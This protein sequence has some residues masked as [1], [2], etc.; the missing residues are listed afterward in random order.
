MLI[1][2]MKLFQALC[3]VTKLLS[4]YIIFKYANCVH[5]A[6]VKISLF[7]EFLRTHVDFCGTTRLTVERT[8]FDSLKL[9]CNFLFF[10]SKVYINFFANIFSTK[11]RI[12][13]R[14]VFKGGKQ[15]KSYWNL[16]T[17]KRFSLPILVIWKYNFYCHIY[18]QMRYLRHLLTFLI[19]YRAIKRHN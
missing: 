10:C 15:I 11:K 1:L 18:T 4:T 12:R 7:W 9:L 16:R 13:L 5:R 2:T 6:N 17:L 8:I 3:G 19:R 14:A